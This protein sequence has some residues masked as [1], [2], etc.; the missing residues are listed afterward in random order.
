VNLL[1]W[2][3]IARLVPIAFLV[4]PA[5]IVG[6]WLCDLSVKPFLKWLEGLSES[7]DRLIKSL[8]DG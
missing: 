8:T 2:D 6:W 5:I 4:A 7:L 3:E 1:T